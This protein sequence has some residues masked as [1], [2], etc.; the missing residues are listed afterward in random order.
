MLIICVILH[1][2]QRKRNRK[3]GNGRKDERKDERKRFPGKEVP[4]PSSRRKNNRIQRKAHLP[5][6][7]KREQAEIEKER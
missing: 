6:T 7:G 4:R 5:G 3:T 1:V 2:E